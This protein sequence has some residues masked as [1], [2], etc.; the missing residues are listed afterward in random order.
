MR[1]I[2][3]SAGHHLKDSGAI[4]NGYKENTL[5]I[6]LRDL[7]IE[8]IKQ[9]KPNQK[10]IKDDDKETLSQVVSRFRKTIKP[11]DFWLEFHFDSSGNGTAS[12]TTSL[13]K[14]G[15]N[16]KSKEVGAELSKM[17][18]SVLNIMDRKVKSEK[19]SNRGRLAML[20]VTENSVLLEVGFISNKLDM[21]EY[22]EW[23]YWVSDE[24]AR[25]VIK[26]V[27]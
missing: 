12:G 5:N 27:S 2:Y 8:R 20:H 22:A 14:E 9:L 16:S 1:S 4:G 19:D 3:L 15:A 25:I 21:S 23:K 13:V 10:V 18:S 26:A 24:I 7:V 11:D 6:E 17:V